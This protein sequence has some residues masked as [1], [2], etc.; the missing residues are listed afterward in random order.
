MLRRSFDRAVRPG[1]LLVLLVRFGVRV[2]VPPEVQVVVWPD[3][4]PRGGRASGWP[5]RALSDVGARSVCCAVGRRARVVW[6][7]AGCGASVVSCAAGSRA[8]L[9]WCAVGCGARMFRR[10]AGWVAWCAAGVRIA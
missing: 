5:L 1:G 10:A 3:A 4:G 8:G 9:I 6:C 7:S 2:L